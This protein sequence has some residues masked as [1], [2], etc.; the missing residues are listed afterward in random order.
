MLRHIN[1]S[2]VIEV[3]SGSSSCVMLDTN[4]HYLNG[5]MDL[6]FIDPY[7]NKMPS[8]PQNSHGKTQLISQRVQDVD[9][10]VFK[11]LKENDILFIDSTRVAKVGSDVNDVIFR[12][13]PNLNAGVYVHFHDI[14]FP[15]EYPKNWVLSHGKYWN[16]IYLLRAFLQFND[17]FEIVIMNTFLQQEYTKFFRENMPLCLK[18]RGGSIWLRKK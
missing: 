5:K 1:P 16:E 17:A 2:Q 18:N 3:G 6:T 8:V 9:I 7:P 12:I 4:R 10:N 13:I 14:F 15:F 11:T